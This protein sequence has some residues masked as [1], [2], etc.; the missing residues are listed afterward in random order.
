MINIIKRFLKLLLKIVVGLLLLILIMHLI[1]G[2]MW[3][4][5][6]YKPL[7]KKKFD[8]REWKAA[9]G[10][11]LEN[12]CGMYH[13]LTR[14]H[15]RKGM[16]I[17][18]VEELLGEEYRWRYSKDGKVKCVSYVM[19]V[20]YSNALSIVPM[21]LYACFNRSGV[22]IRYDRDMHYEMKGTYNIKTKEQSCLKADIDGTGIPTSDCGIDDPW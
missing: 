14:N 22:L 9:F 5:A 3:D 7:M 1:F 16:T 19:G 20:C 15:L 12:R 17:K 13:D 11:T 2:G 21:S 18:Q 4:W 6:A 10:D 8:S